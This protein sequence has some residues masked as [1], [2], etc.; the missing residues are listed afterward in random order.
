MLKSIWCLSVVH[1]GFYSKITKK[2][3]VSNGN[4]FKKCMQQRKDGLYINT[5]QRCIDVHSDQLSQAVELL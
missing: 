5:T 4:E 3:S 2:K 1:S